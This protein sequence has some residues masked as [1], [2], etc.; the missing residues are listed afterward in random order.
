[1]HSLHSRTG[2]QHRDQTGFRG[3]PSHGQYHASLLENE[4]IIH[5]I[6]SFLV[7]HLAP[8]TYGIRDQMGYNASDVMLLVRDVGSHWERVLLLHGP[9]LDSPASRKPGIQEKRKDFEM[10]K[11]TIGLGSQAIGA[12]ADITL[13]SFTRN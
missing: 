8:S 11:W 7:V 10:N 2:S 9:K 6:S 4:P 13:S 5:L 12:T 3:F 1:M